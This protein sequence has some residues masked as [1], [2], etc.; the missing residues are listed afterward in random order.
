[1]IMTVGCEYK[2]TLSSAA[3]ALEVYHYCRFLLCIFHV[4]WVERALC[5]PMSRVA[6][7]TTT[8]VIVRWCTFWRVFGLAVASTMT[9]LT[10]LEAFACELVH[11]ETRCSVREQCRITS[12]WHSR[13]FGLCGQFSS[14]KVGH[15]RYEVI[16]RLLVLHLHV[17]RQIDELLGVRLMIGVLRRLLWRGW[18]HFLH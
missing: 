17:Q 1:M 12:V 7:S 18:C 2:H 16:R 8:I 10:T 11:N 15:L 13:S 4:A 6:A 14:D 5:H 3:A 9:C